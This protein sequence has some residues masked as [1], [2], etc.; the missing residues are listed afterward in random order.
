MLPYNISGIIFDTFVNY[1]IVIF[2]IGFSE[3][4]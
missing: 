2:S 4:K 3:F 1:I